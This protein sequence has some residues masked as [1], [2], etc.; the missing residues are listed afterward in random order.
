[1]IIPDEIRR[2]IRDLVWQI[3]DEIGWSELSDTDRA[4]HYELWTRD[5]RI[6]GRLAHFMD[7]RKVRVY[8]KD[9]LLKPYERQ[10]LSKVEQ[11]VLGRLNIGTYQ[12]AV[13]RFIKPHAILLEG[14]ELICWGKSRDWKSIL[15]ASFERAA[16]D[17]RVRSTAVMLLESGKTLED[18]ARQLVK[19][20][21]NHLKIDRL[22]WMD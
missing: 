17:E 3:A 6:G 2:Q 8:I 10:R 5:Q 19:S 14:G 15:M 4:Q 21:A 16:L 22:E 9:S 7:A 1:M 20:A 18:R 13:D 11:Q 12:V